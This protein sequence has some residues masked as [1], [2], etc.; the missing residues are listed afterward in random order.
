MSLQGKKVLVGLT[1]GIACY[2]VPYLVRA[3]HKV[4]AEIQVVMTVAATKF[5]TPLTLES[6]SNRPVAV[7]MFPEREF[8]STR[9]IELAEW[10][11]LVVIA[12]ATANFLGKTASGVSDDLLTT[13]VCATPRPVIIA[14]AMNP[15]M[16]NNPVT[17]RNVKT[18]QDLGYRMIG[19]D[20]GEMACDHTGVGR[21]V[22]PDAIFETVREFFEADAK[23]KVLTGRR[24]LITAGPCR[25][26]LDPVR[27]ISNRS[28]GKMGYALAEAA[29]ALG[30][31]TVLVS[32]PTNLAPPHG[33]TFVPV[34]TTEDMHRAVRDHLAGTDCLIM[35]A[36]PA[37][38]A[39][40]VIAAEKIK[41]GDS[42]RTLD[43]R[44]TV[45]IL[46]SIA[47]DKPDGLVLVGFAL[48]T[49][50]GLE[51][52]RHKLAEK[53]LD[54]IVLNNPRDPG[55]GFDVDTNKVTVLYPGRKPE[56]LALQSKSE[57]A[58]ELLERLA[59]MIH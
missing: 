4:E 58:Y 47:K 51:N 44:P 11:D 39:P 15:G 10:P 42:A 48:E 21:M 20:E 41:K 9:H 40:D 14:P 55:A 50:N 31:E 19:P 7:E 5:I 12:P 46:K 38:F 27:Y 52:A 30:A 29:V 1:G 49:E 22:E 28:S 45:D 24:V 23:K 53:H 6:V 59:A 3:L 18:L 43:L 34:E 2:K 16:W 25:E 17:Q 56:P 57:L 36:A 37:D 33:A 13:I 35:A 54:L 8:V 32:G 26:P